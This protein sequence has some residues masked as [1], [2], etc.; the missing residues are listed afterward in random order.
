[1]PVVTPRFDLDPDPTLGGANASNE[2][3]AT[4]KAVKD[5]VDNR[6][7]LTV[8]QTYNGT[9]TNAQSG[10]AV[11]EAISDRSNT[12]LSNLTSTG[13]NIANWSN[14]VTNCITEIPQDIKLELS[15]TT[16]TLKAGSKVYIPNG[17]TGDTL[18]FTEIT[19]S[20]DLTFSTWGSAS[21]DLMMFYNN[22]A[23]AG[24][25]GSMYSGETQPTTAGL[26][27]DTANNYM[28]YSSNG[29]SWAIS[30]HAL[31][32]G[33]V[34]RSSGTPT[35]IDQ[36]FN[37]FGYMG[38]TIFAL[39]GVKGLI[40]N[41]RNADG[42]LK[43]IEFETSSVLI[44]TL[45]GS[46]RTFAGIVYSG[47]NLSLYRGAKT[48]ITYDK[49]SNYNIDI[50]NNSTWSMLPIAN[51]IGDISLFTP[52]TSFHALDYNDS[53]TIAGWAMPSS[54]YISLTLGASGT[55]YTAPA[56]GWACIQ[57]KAT[58][59]SQFLTIYRTGQ[60]SLGS[61]ADASASAT[62]ALRGYI[63]VEKGHNFV[64][65]YTVAGSTQQF[66]FIYAEGEN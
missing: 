25:S 45:T 22:G 32:L 66:I 13:Q 38:S 40:P 20:S 52:K 28:K 8:D 44:S 58:A 47:G 61:Y 35:A 23:L 49:N 53:S 9:S 2:V 64:V 46:N 5:Y 59:V 19:L 3:G 4:Q 11:A 60:N 37:G 57:K 36:V 29:T 1:M 12:S 24:Y 34:G 39:P 51:T 56:N 33:L 17:K 31:P 41:G 42:S 55:E 50:P 63:P 62:Q 18:N 65:V 27:Y 6:P 43:N 54:K 14:N 30:N 16:L 48:N 7:G 15:G 10:T 26:W 21:T